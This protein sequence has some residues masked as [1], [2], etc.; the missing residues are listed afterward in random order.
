MASQEIIIIKDGVFEK[1]IR[2]RT[3]F[4]TRRDTK[5]ITVW[6]GFRLIHSDLLELQRFDS[7]IMT[8]SS[9]NLVRFSVVENAVWLSAM[10]ALT[11]C[12]VAS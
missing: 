7:A 2:T 12:A 9:D 5:V 1:T 10:K 11:N 6:T 4:K 3:S 8:D